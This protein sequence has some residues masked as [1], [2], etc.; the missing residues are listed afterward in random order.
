[1]RTARGTSGPQMASR[2][3]TMDEGGTGFQK[4]RVCARVCVCTPQVV[5]VALLHATD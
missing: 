4:V 3:S 2:L 1:M 5:R